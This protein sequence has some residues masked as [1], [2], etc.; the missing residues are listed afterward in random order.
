MATCTLYR[1]VGSGQRE[2]RQ[3]M[4]EIW[5]EPVVRIMA[6]ST[7][8]RELGSHMVFGSIVLNLMARNTIRLGRSGISQVTGRA[9]NDC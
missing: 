9:L 8:G 2:T 7:I 4:I 1:D 5:I 6:H 3:R